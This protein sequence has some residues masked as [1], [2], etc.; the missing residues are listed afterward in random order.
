[1]GCKECAPRALPQ[2]K[3]GYKSKKMKRARVR[4]LQ[5]SRAMQREADIAPYLKSVLVCAN[6]RAQ[7][8]DRAKLR[9]CYIFYDKQAFFDI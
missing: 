4:R 8:L 9:G 6:I 2:R 7:F 5:K 3:T 1:M